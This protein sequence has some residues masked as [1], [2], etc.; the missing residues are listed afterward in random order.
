MRPLLA[1]LLA[2]LPACSVAEA[3]PARAPGQ[4]YADALT[5]MCDVDRLAGV[6][7]DADP[8]TVGQRRTEWIE[9]HAENPDSIELRV[10]MSVKGA[11]EQAEMLR[12]QAKQAGLPRC[13]LA[14]SLEKLGAGG[15]SP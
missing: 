3:Q 15:L 10:L 5:V 14:D 12:S 8:I 1:L 11:S 9:G 7:P 13:A 4:C 6:D 2:A